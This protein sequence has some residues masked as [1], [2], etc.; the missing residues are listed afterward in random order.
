MP[1]KMLTG[2]TLTFGSVSTIRNAFAIFRLRPADVRK[3]A[4]PAVMHDR[5]HRAHREPRSVDD[6]PDVAVSA[7]WLSCPTSTQSSS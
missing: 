3:L 7:A 2:I 4:G 6:A 5:V 1:A